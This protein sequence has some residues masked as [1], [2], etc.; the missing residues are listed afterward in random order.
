MIKVR[1]NKNTQK[2]FNCKIMQNSKKKKQIQ[3]KN[4]KYEKMNLINKF[5]SQK[6]EKMNF[7]F[8]SIS[9]I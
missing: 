6:I 3:S 8:K 7:K 4:I 5:R 9:F 2:A 1:I